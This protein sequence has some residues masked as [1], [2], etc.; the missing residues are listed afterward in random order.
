MKLQYGTISKEKTFKV[1][2]LFSSNVYYMKD[3]MLVINA[4]TINTMTKEDFI[5]NL[6]LK[7]SSYKI[8]NGSGT[9]VTSSTTVIGTNYRLVADGRTLYIA[10]IGDITGDGKILSND[11]LQISRYLVDLRSLTGVYKLA[12][13]VSN[14][15]KI[16]SNDS[17]LISRFLVGLKGSL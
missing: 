3:G 17:L 5:K 10:L 15:G 13:D 4:K 12:A 16:M 1:S 14:D 8:L 6:G 11:S 9:D 2:V 7:V